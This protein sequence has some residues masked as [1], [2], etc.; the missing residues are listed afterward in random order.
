MIK[1]SM[2][3]RGHRT[4]ISLEAPFWAYL[5]TVALSRGLSTSALVAEIDD[6]RS[7]LLISGNDTGGLSSMIRV[8]LLETA[9]KNGPINSG[10]SDNA[11]TG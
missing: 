7:E 5:K 11:I 10:A 1:K 4:S 2:T 6:L 8:Y 3:I 9:L